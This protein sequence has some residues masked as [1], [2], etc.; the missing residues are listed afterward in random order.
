VK[1]AKLYVQTKNVNQQQITS[2]KIA[3]FDNVC[4]WMINSYFKSYNKKHTKS[5]FIQFRNWILYKEGLKLIQSVVEKQTPSDIL[6]ATT[7]M[8]HG[9]GWVKAPKMGLF[10]LL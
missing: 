9:F 10:H 2:N 5:S 4:M 1:W 3:R 8:V 7:K 6:K